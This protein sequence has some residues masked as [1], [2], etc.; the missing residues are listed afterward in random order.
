LQNSD[1]RAKVKAELREGKSSRWYVVPGRGEDE[2]YGKSPLKQEHWEHSLVI[3]SCLNGEQYNNQTVAKI[4][5]SMGVDPFEALLNLLALDPQTRKVFIS[6][7]EDGLRTFMKQP[8]IAFG[9]DGGLVKAI[10]RPGI[11]SPVLYA[12][13]PHVL[14]KYVREEKLLTLEEAVRKM[15]SL[16][17]QFLGLK[18]RG[19]LLEGM[20][21]DVVVFDSNTVAGNPIYDPAADRHTVYLNKGIELVIVN[22]QIVLE[23]DT[24]T[25]A[26]PGRVLR[27]GSLGSTS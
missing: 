10:R 13:F 7:N 26:L 24:H 22:G 17:A 21:A 3:L 11:P 25:G 2:A 6:P 5:E 23:G 1:E 12:S 27:S 20:Q 9:T 15:T 19:L 18:D 8:W 14:G 16:P 4:A